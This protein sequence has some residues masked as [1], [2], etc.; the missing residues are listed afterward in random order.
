MV[1]LAG[2]EAQ[3]ILY[4]L[5]TINIMVYPF[6]LEM[7]PNIWAIYNKKFENIRLGVYH[8]TRPV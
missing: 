6:K 2:R 5:P 4:L 1:Q 7:G 8:L 3:F